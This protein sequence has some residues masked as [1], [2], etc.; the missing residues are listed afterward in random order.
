MATVSSTLKLF[1]AFSGPLKQVTNAMNMTISV[2]QKMNETTVR[3]SEITKTLNIAKRQLASAEA[4]LKISAES[5]AQAQEKLNNQ[6]RKSQKETHSLLTTVRN[7][8]AAYLGFQTIKNTI[9]STVGAGM[10]QQQFI[11]TLSARTGSEQLG[12]AIYQTLRKDALRFGQDVEAAIKGGMSFLSQTQD[13]MQLRELNRLA[14][15]LAKLNPAEG[16]EGA[17]FSLKE[18]ASG[19][20]TSIAERFNL[21]RSMLKD[22]AARKAGERGDIEGFIKGMDELL[23]KQNMSQK[24]FEK[25]LDS[26]AAKWQATIN[27]FKDSLTTTGMV[28]LEAFTPFF[29]LIN[30]AASNNQ[31]DVMF[32]A[33]AITLTIVGN[34][35]T[36]VTQGMLW[37]FNTA[38]EYWPVI[39]GMLGVLISYYLPTIL[40][41]LWAMI[42]PI[43]ASAGAWMAA[44]WPLLLVMAAVG[45]LIF[46]LMKLGVTTEQVVGFM[47]GLFYS[48]FAVLYNIV[49][50]LWNLFAM[51]AEF[52]INIF[53]DPTYAVKKLFYDLA[54]MVI[55]NMAAMAGSF[56]KAASALANAF[57]SAVNIAIKGINWLIKALNNIPGINIKQLGELNGVSVDLFSAGIKAFANTLKPPT[58]DRNVVNLPRM[59]L[60]SIPDAYQRGYKAGGKM[61]NN[62]SEMMSGITNIGNKFDKYKQ[63]A[64]PKIS[65]VGNVGSGIGKSPDIGKVGKVGEVGKINDTVDISSE[66]L[67]YIRELAE[68]KSIQNFVT[69]TP[70]VQ[71]T[72]GD[73]R[74][75]ADIDRIVSKIEDLMKNEIVSSAAGVYG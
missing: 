18:L 26:P 32:K 29:D 66:D 6:L 12:K 44:H 27:R 5:A 75:E 20:Y 23:N 40:T 41:K 48:F 71:V 7:L 42:Q 19:D 59:D 57:V 64:I 70:T 67:K 38:V 8:I 4:S 16:L 60:M 33:L 31:L 47:V 13:P 17:V 45:L 61:I 24:A 52:L 51:F 35:L 3:N 25:M 11:D 1:D 36:W 65:N 56:D 72:T 2:M 21:S 50:N 34:L 46:M 63:A 55:D 73:I 62:F 14:M 53:I 22:S 43:L 30:N 15:R 10:S 68:I 69:L 28:A 49:A 58:S 37:L 39:A 54:K 9:S 74:E